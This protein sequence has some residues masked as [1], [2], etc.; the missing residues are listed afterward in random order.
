MMVTV[1]S[2]GALERRMRV[3]LP[4][5][6]IEQEVESRLKR[7][8]RTAKIKGFR[9]GKIPPKVIRQ[10][11]GA[12]VRQ[13]VLS[14]LMQKSYS[15]AVIQEKLNPAAGPSIEPVAAED[16][17]AFAYIAT[18]EVLPE[19][20]LKDL[21]KIKVERPEVDITDADRDDMIE[22][23]R[24]QKAEWVTVERKS[25]DGDR[26]TVDFEG[27]LDGEP[28]EGGTG[29]NVEVVLGQGQMLPDFE[30]GLKGVEAGD[31]TSFKVK[32]PKEYHAEDL[33][34]KKVDFAVKVHSVDEQELPPLDDS[35]AETFGVEEGGL[36]QLRVEVGENM[37]R[38][39]RQKIKGDVREQVM[40]G[41]VELN[42]IEVPNAMVQQEAHNMQHEAMQRMGI[43][44]HDKAPPAEGFREAAERR[45]RLGLL[46]RQ[47]ISEQELTVDTDRVRAHLEEMCAG[48]EDADAMV[49]NYMSNPQIVQQVEPSV[50]E[51][52]ALERL[53]EQGQVETKKVGFKEY[54]NP[55]Q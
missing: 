41:L 26:V 55:P 19:V 16:K 37:E 6:R 12:Q 3:E 27:T 42:P 25:K 22:N 9:P 35:L 17:S 2:T 30:K 5:Q 10:H 39:A 43:Q 36:S 33:R 38:E 34:G 48:Y 4:A 46:L 47:Y 21:D 11:Y 54:M 50:L 45:V 13:E 49:A 24:G 1:E 53:L 20:T 14:D 29:E 52:Q 40:A 28:I 23:L 8:S 32:F 15:D 7:V 18:F 31:E 44:D 51:E